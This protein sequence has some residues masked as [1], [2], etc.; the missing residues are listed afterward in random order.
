VDIEEWYH[1]E[2]VKNH[3]GLNRESRLQKTLDETLQ[4]LGS[5][6]TGATFFVVGELAERNPEAI[7]KISEK[8]YEI[9]F[10]GFYHEPLARS[11][12]DTFR[13]EVKRFGGLIKEKCRGFRAPSFS[14]S[15]STKWALRVL[16]EE[17]YQYDSSVFPA[18]TP[19]YGQYG[20]PTRP[21]KLSDK[22]VGAEDANGKLWEFSLLVYK[23]AGIRIP[24]AGGFYLRFFPVDIISRAIRKTNEK[25]YPA[26]L[27]FHNWEIDPNLPRLRLGFY[28]S[29]VTYHNL[30]ETKRKHE[31]LLS[32]FE[33]V[34]IRDYME[35]QGL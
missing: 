28:R 10:H 2:Y 4:L 15:N 35:K 29:F 3:L 27:F 30:N 34:G 1:A 8:G 24:L 5:H 7:G 13:S 22:D 33:F 23:F 25:G 18:K 6:D 12:V 16:E 19:L 20:A 26:V 14:L 31:S 21:Y 17:G 11:N 9:G 32:K